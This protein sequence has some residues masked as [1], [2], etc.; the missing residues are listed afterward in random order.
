MSSPEHHAPAPKMLPMIPS[1]Y[2]QE[3]HPEYIVLRVQSL[4]RRREGAL[5]V[6]SSISRIRF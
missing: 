2:T 6:L 1:V 4:L 3:V 5:S